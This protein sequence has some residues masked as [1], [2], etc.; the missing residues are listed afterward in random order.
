MIYTPYIMEGIRHQ[1]KR[2]RVK[3][4]CRLEM[5]QHLCTGPTSSPVRK[6]LFGSPPIS[7]RKN[8]QEMPIM[9]ISRWAFVIAKT[10]MKGRRVI[11]GLIK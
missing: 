5:Y 3:A 6:L 4:H 9:I 11:K 7:A 10:M 8:E 2:L 1:S